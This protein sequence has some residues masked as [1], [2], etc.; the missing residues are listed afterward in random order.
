MKRDGNL[1]QWIIGI[2]FAILGAIFVGIGVALFVYEMRVPI[3][4]ELFGHMMSFIFGVIGLPF[5]FIGI[6]F[7]IYCIRKKKQTQML[8]ETG[9]QIWATVTGYEVNVNVSVNGRHPIRLNCEYRDP[10]TG[11]VI[12]YR[13]GNCW[14]PGEGYVGQSAAIYVNPNHPR[15]YYVDTDSIPLYGGANVIDYR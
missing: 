2:I 3:G 6:G 8:L 15:E 7:L 5:L 9:Q 12:L 11:S 10:Y 1:A 13:S 14:N 4:T